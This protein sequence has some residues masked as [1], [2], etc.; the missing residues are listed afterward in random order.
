M[1]T[2]EISFNVQRTGD[3]IYV[4]F[5]PVNPELQGIV[6]HGQDLPIISTVKAAIDDYM[7]YARLEI[8]NTVNGIF[9]NSYY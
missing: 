9:E 4:E 5:H 8:L 1:Q 2:L 6:F 7:P 3:T